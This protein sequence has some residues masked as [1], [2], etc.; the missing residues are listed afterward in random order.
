MAKKETA[1]ALSD[2]QRAFLDESFPV[3]QDDNN[4]LTLPRF[5]MLAKDITEETGKGKEKK[6]KVIEAS[7]TFYIEKDEGETNEEGK[8][9]WT[10]T[11]LEGETQEVIITYYR[12]QLK[13]YDE[14]LKKYYSTP[15]YDTP[16]QVLPLYL[17]KKIV[18]RG[19]EKELQAMYP[20]LT[21]SGKPSS[22][23]QK[24]TLLFV[25]FKD[26]LHQFNLGMASGWSFSSYKRSINPSTVLTRL[27]SIEETKGSNTYC[28]TTF[29][30]VRPVSSDEFDIVKE[31]VTLVKQSV[32]NDS[33][34]LL[35]SGSPTKEDV[36]FEKLAAKVQGDL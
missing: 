19:T 36:E 6:I 13:Y 12:Y 23:L 3:S 28:K 17:D 5:G 21:A 24:L 18:K 8:K 25:I 30:N 26:E 32:E 1:L 20:K 2:E 27:G 11:F 29:T 31:N 34:F 9:V 15:V 10:K 22:A 14:P 35:A 4:R 33:R 16:D 7:G